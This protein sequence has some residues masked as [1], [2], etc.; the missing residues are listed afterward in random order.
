LCV[1]QYAKGH[2]SGWNNVE[3]W[4]NQARSLSQYAAEGIRQAR[5]AGRQLVS[6]NPIKYK[7]CNNLLKI[8]QVDLKA[9][10][11]FFYLTNTAPSSSREIV[12]GFYRY[13]LRSLPQ[14]FHSPYLWTPSVVNDKD[15][16]IQ[17]YK[18]IGRL[19][20]GKSPNHQIFWCQ[21]FPSNFRSTF[22]FNIR[23]MCPEI[24]NSL[25]N[26]GLKW[27]PYMTETVKS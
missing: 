27:K 23:V 16:D 25:D 7:F 11:Q 3:Q 19:H 6:Q 17:C 24:L 4:R 21:N 8:F 9:C 18:L 15:A 14:T 5:Q 10:L 22:A 20:F 12:T 1:L 26:H 13:V 2:L